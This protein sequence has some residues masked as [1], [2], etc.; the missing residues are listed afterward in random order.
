[1]VKDPYDIT[2]V[3]LRLDEFLD[4]AGPLTTIDCVAQ[5]VL[6]LLAKDF[7]SAEPL[8][9]IVKSDPALALAVLS[10]AAGISSQSLNL[11]QAWNAL[12]LERIISSVLATAVRSINLC[13]SQPTETSQL[14]RTEL[15]RHSLA[16][17]LISQAAA[18]AD[19]SDVE[20]DS[21]SAYLAG[22]LHDLGKL[23][24]SASTPKSLERAWQLASTGGYGLLDA[25]GQVFEF[26]HIALG[27]RL[28]QRLSLPPLVGKCIWL[29]HHSYL[30]LPEQSVVAVIFADILARELSLGHSGNP[31]L[32]VSAEELAGHIGLSPDF[33]A[34]LRRSIPEQLNDT[35]ELLG[36]D[37]PRRPE[38]C[39]QNLARVV[40]NIANLQRQLTKTQNDLADAEGLSQR[41]SQITR[42][43]ARMV[44]RKTLDAEMAQLASGAAHELNNP[45]AVIAGRSQLLARQETDPD[46]KEVLNLIDQQARQASAITS[47]LL[48]AVQ[49]PTP[50]PQ[51]IQLEPI[52]RKLCAA[53]AGKAQATNS[54]VISDL[55][56]ELPPAFID[57]DMFEKS[58][59]EILK[60]ALAAL[61]SQSGTIRISCR[62]D[63]LQEKLLLEVADSGIGMEATVARNV[64]VPFFSS[65][66]AGRGRGLGL[67]LAKTFIEAN[68]GRLWFRSQAGEGTT[69]WMALPLAK[70]G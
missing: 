63:Q 12:S 57:P 28:A 51:P 20:Q 19:P 44:D 5:R 18:T 50:Q 32:P 26:D 48:A 68:Q 24:F 14:N 10:M 8:K 47:D 11:E 38:R 66:P 62:F 33:V 41:F 64:F 69:V 16:V 36:F 27:R 3:N 65:L 15:Y 54:Q 53:L 58:L 46:K 29:H 52:I 43:A 9:P 37:E 22:L 2:A 67:S 30:M 55:P 34:E 56:D 23:I 42:Q 61:G 21:E 31:D 39:M 6:E 60:N 1:M 13:T 45:L 35:G 59:L 4:A 25:E 49:P 17:G 70:E 40:S 7:S